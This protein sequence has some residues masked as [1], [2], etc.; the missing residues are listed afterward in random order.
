[1][2]NLEKQYTLFYR[3]GP[4]AN[5]QLLA[6]KVGRMLDEDYLNQCSMEEIGQLRDNLIEAY[7]R[8]LMK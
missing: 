4:I 1:M 5:C 8:K 7:N 2:D 6:E 3:S